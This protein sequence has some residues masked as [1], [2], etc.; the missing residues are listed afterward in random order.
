M[1]MSS[2]LLAVHEICPIPHCGEWDSLSVNTAQAVVLVV[3]CYLTGFLVTESL[4]SIEAVLSGPPLAGM[5]VTAYLLSSYW[6]VFTFW[7]EQFIRKNAWLITYQEVEV[8]PLSPVSVETPERMPGGMGPAWAIAKMWFWMFAMLLFGKGFCNHEVHPFLHRHITQS[9][10]VVFIIHRLLDVHF[11]RSLKDAGM[12]RPEHMVMVLIVLVFVCSFAIY[13][14]LVQVPIIAFCF[15]IRDID[16]SKNILPFCPGQKTD[17]VEM[18]VEDPRTMPSDADPNGHLPADTES[19]RGTVNVMVAAP[20]PTNHLV[21]SPT[22]HADADPSA[23]NSLCADDMALFV[24]AV[25]L[26]GL[27]YGDTT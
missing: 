1:G 14:L 5:A 23:L 19:N 7:G 17:K 6:P 27:R 26:A 25:S 21:P 20:L 8:Y 15:G 12:D 10:I 16:L 22:G 13:A 9:S 2:F 18:K 4:D 11:S 3:I 24:G